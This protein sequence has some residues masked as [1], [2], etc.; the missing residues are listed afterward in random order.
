MIIVRSS[1]VV[2]VP[3]ELAA[4]HWADNAPKRLHDGDSVP[5]EWLVRGN[6]CRMS[7]S[8]EVV[9]EPFSTARARAAFSVSVEVDVSHAVSASADV[10]GAGRGGTPCALRSSP[11]AE[12]GLRE[13]HSDRALSRLCRRSAHRSLV[14]LPHR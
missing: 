2:E 8:G 13:L 3:L 14:T 5:D 6:A 9:F 1:I 11:I 7:C 10:V 4:Q 12:D